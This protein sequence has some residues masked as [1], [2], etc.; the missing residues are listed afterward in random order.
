MSNI[1]ELLA[2]DETVEFTT[3]QMGALGQAANRLIAKQRQIEKQELLLKELKA[4]ERK[5]N[6][7]EIP[8]LMDNLGFEK[9]T[10]SD[11]RV[12]AVKDSVQVA[13]PAPMREQ[14]YGWM[15]KYGHGD[16]I[17]AAV[18]AKFAR[19]D[20]DKAF[21]AMR[22]LEALGIAASSTESVHPGTLKA[23][24][25]EELAQGHILPTQFFKV[26]IAKVTTVK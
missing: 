25:R 16:L 2:Q 26:H 24:A 20:K 22:A 21:D 23:W 6:Q 13:I 10:L 9:I 7:L 15:D 3:E 18:T 8:E 4:E 17:K 14:A 5:I 12:I 11:G 19:G 1:S